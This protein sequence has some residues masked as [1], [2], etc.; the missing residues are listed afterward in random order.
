[1]PAHPAR[2][3]FCPP[4]RAA[5]ICALLL[6]GAALAHAQGGIKRWVDERG[7]VHYG[8]A[9]PAAQAR[10]GKPVT[11]VTPVPAISTDASARDQAQARLQ[12]YRDQMAQNA[13][14]P[15]SAASAAPAAARSQAP[16]DDNSCL[17]QWQRYDAAY[18]CLDGHRAKGGIVAP[19][20]LQKCP[21]LKQP[22]CPLPASMTRN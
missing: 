10:T 2:R 17:A 6:G 11:E 22:D 14:A 12:A 13:T 15:A 8:D 18:A 9:V 3:P 7:V 21:V 1:M 20:A 19:D 5:A 16:A 4:V